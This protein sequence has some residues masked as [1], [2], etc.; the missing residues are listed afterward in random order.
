MKKPQ[1]LLQHY[2][3][4]CLIFMFASPQTIIFPSNYTYVEV[5]SSM[6]ISCSLG[7][8][9]ESMQ[10]LHLDKC[11]PQQDCERLEPIGQNNTTKFY[12]QHLDT[13]STK[14]ISYFCITPSESFSSSS[15]LEVMVGYKPQLP[16][17]LNCVS[18]NRGDLRCNWEVPEN[19]INNSVL[20]HWTVTYTDGAFAYRPCPESLTTKLR[21][22]NFTTGC[23]IPPVDVAISPYGLYDTFVPS[24]NYYMNITLSNKIGVT[25]RIYNITTRRIVKLSHPIV[26]I[27]PS[28]NTLQLS[29][30]LP[31]EFR[32]NREID[33]IVV[34]NITYRASW[35]NKPRMVIF[36]SG[37]DSV[38]TTLRNCIPFTNYII[39]ITARPERSLYWSDVK[40]KHIKTDPDVPYWAPE[41]SPGLYYVHNQTGITLFHKPLQERYW[42][43]E[44]CK[45]N[46]VL[47]DEINSTI[48]EGNFSSSEA[49]LTIPK[50]I[51]DS[52][53]SASLRYINIEG[54]SENASILFI[55]ENESGL[56]V[57]A[58]EIQT[59]GY[60]ITWE[61]DD[62]V[63]ITSVTIMWCT[64][65]GQKHCEG[66]IKW[67]NFQRPGNGVRLTD[68]EH[69]KYLIFGVSVQY[70][71]NT[72][73][74]LTFATCYYQQPY[75]RDDF[76][77]A[78]NARHLKKNSK[79][80]LVIDL[81]SSVCQYESRPLTYQVFYQKHRN[82]NMR[83]PDDF[84]LNRTENVRHDLRD[85]SL[86]N[87]YPGEQYDICLGVILA[88]NHTVYSEI[89]TV[90]FPE[91]DT[92]ADDETTAVAIL[93]PILAVCIIMF[94]A[95]CIKRK[96][97]F[98]KPDIKM[99]DIESYVN[100]GY[101]NGLSDEE[102]DIRDM[103]DSGTHSSPESISSEDQGPEVDRE[104][105]SSSG[106]GSTKCESDVFSVPTTPIDSDKQTLIFK[107]MMEKPKQTHTD[108]TTCNVSVMPGEEKAKVTYT[109]EIPHISS[110]CSSPIDSYSRVEEEGNTLHDMMDDD[111]GDISGGYRDVMCSNYSSTC[112][113]DSENLDTCPSTPELERQCNPCDSDTVVGTSQTFSI[114]SDS[115]Q[116]TV[117]YATGFEIDSSGKNG[118]DSCQESK[119]SEF[120]I[121]L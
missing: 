95:Y 57:M 121:T 24:P 98:E 9:N 115:S 1:L 55:N 11:I 29:L 101:N 37:N 111:S 60:W 64:K 107:M 58:E 79:Q 17:K 7:K 91:S 65:I 120:A 71:N 113:S 83:C 52:H 88:N 118:I 97:T 41:T 5:N 105:V 89:Q 70:K 35:I 80:E 32:D 6:A 21:S 74:G 94:M 99:P 110:S 10:D 108:L 96:C 66:D 59:K 15:H 3:L 112:A 26:T 90:S 87:I 82:V 104:S 109:S 38:T 40:T 78:F 119:D 36:S 30:N 116:S 33:D 92:I 100:P 77:L 28:S 23:Y 117:P 103:G 48:W 31:K 75:S 45:V 42:N 2:V 49:F 39:Q 8:S 76:K 63:P 22:N 13:V 106:I 50:D 69:N 73:S 51:S 20:S 47:S 86:T 25:S 16:E 43:A 12:R 102:K 56:F 34:Y 67:K 68:I 72:S 46:V 53:Y 4:L 81:V 18:N 44:D 19:N 54:P 84:S 27:K 93:V 61:M 85:V 14:F 114:G 62:V